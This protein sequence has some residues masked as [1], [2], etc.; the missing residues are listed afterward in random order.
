MNKGVESRI[1]DQIKELRKQ[2]EFIK[3]NIVKLS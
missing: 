1:E 3:S 2:I